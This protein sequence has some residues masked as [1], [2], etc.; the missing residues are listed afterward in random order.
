AIRAEIQRLRKTVRYND[1]LVVFFA[2][3]GVKTPEGFFLLTPDSDL[4][5]AS[6][7]TDTALSGDELRSGSL[8]GNFPC[9]VLLLV[10]AC[11]AGAFGRRAPAAKDPMDVLTKKGFQ[12]A[13]DDLARGLA[14]D[15]AGGAILC[16]AMGHEKAQERSG[17]GLFTKAIVQALNFSDARVPHRNHRLYLHH[18]YAFVLD[19][20]A[21]ESEEEQHPFLV[22]P[23]IVESFPLVQ[24]SPKTVPQGP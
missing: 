13:T 14:D 10:D 9:Q 17:Q 23:S 1:L 2:G 4:A 8:L 19:R 15:E 18:L 22:L 12:P 5:K 24:F 11:H 7:L 21:E 16:A 6:R 3:H 20:V